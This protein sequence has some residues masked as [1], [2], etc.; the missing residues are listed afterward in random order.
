MV[1]DLALAND[2]LK[3][4]KQGYEKITPEKLLIKKLDK[5]ALKTSILF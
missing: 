2:F 5:N 1:V 4:E 3:R